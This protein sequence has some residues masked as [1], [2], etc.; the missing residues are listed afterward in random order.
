M[1]KTDL[2]VLGE[3]PLNAEPPCLIE[4]TRHPITP[5]HLAYARNHCMFLPNYAT[6]DSDQ[7]FEPAISDDTPFSSEYATPSD[8]LSSMPGFTGNAADEMAFVASAAEIKNLA[9]E[10]DSY[11]VKIDGEMEG[12]EEKVLNVKDMI[13]SFPR[14]VVVATLIVR[15][16]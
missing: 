13:A 16:V 14:K 1:G 6:P 2:R 10:V 4:L 7:T 5:L 15:H 11:M 8:F 9:S 12:M 3:I